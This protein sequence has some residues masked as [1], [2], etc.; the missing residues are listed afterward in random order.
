M[1]DVWGWLFF[2]LAS[3][4]FEPAAFGGWWTGPIGSLATKKRPG[5]S[6]YIRTYIHLHLARVEEGGVHA[7]MT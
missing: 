5:L 1:S 3:F 4:S 6:T 7:L 2:F